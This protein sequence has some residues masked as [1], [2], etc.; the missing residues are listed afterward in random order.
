MPLGAE[1][2][3]SDESPTAGSGFFPPA[4]RAV[5][6]SCASSFAC[7]AS[8]QQGTPQASMWPHSGPHSLL[9]ISP[10]SLGASLSDGPPPS[11]HGAHCGQ[12]AKDL[13]SAAIG[14]T[15][16]RRRSSQYSAPHLVSPAGLSSGLSISQ[17]GMGHHARSDDP[18]PSTFETGR[19]VF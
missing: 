6:T 11:A 12:M 15:S 14:P 10:R 17:A 4:V 19:S 7:G 5:P 18:G 1:L 3:P 8:P 9:G 13:A 2:P 16:S